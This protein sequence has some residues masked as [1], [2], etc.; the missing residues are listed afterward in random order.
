MSS[1]TGGGSC[2]WRGSTTPTAPRP[3]SASPWER[4]R[5]WTCNTLSLGDSPL[6][7]S[8]LFIKQWHDNALLLSIILQAGA[9]APHSGCC[10]PG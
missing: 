9:F 1:M 5:T 2:Q 10:G 3:P 6:S 4:L 7:A 8:L